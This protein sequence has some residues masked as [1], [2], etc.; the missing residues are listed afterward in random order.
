M[1]IATGLV[2][3]RC[4]IC[5]K[6]EV[7]EPPADGDEPLCAA[8]GRILRGLRDRLSG[9]LGINPN[10]V[11]LDTVL[12][13]DVDSLDLFEMLLDLDGDIG[14]L[15]AVEIPPEELKRCETVEQLIRLIR[16]RQDGELDAI[17]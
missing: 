13:R 17:E 12:P 8:C 1:R 15:F 11:K 10:S 6:V 14:E 5:G 4:L 7:L 2:D 3:D 9:D 16:R